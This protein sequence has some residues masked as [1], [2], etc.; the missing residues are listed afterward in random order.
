[1]RTFGWATGYALV[2]LGTEYNQAVPVGTG[3]RLRRWPGHSVLRR[4]SS[5]GSAGRCNSKAVAPRLIAA[6][7]MGRAVLSLQ[8]CAVSA[9]EFMHAL[10]GFPPHAR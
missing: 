8:Q 9:Q 4:A 2:D 10:G 6:A 7:L 1:M 5:E 3:K